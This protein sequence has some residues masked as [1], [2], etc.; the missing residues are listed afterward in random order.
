MSE[1]NLN[2]NF[3]P[4]G[5]EEDPTA[6][7]PGQSIAANA[8]APQSVI[9]GHSALHHDLNSASL[10]IALDFRSVDFFSSERSVDWLTSLLPTI[11]KYDAICKKATIDVD[12]FKPFK[13]NQHQHW[14]EPKDMKS[15]QDNVV[16]KVVGVLIRCTNMED[17]KIVLYYP[18]ANYETVMSL[19]PF[20]GLDDKTLACAIKE[21][22]KPEVVVFEG[23]G[24]DKKLRDFYKKSN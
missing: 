23:D 12:P 10:K 24:W 1:R 2:S 11:E 13:R 18:V 15:F 4:E 20:Y 8:T 7:A 16:E 21:A 3:N 6:P 19:A 17:I 22:G 5:L 9:V 14:N